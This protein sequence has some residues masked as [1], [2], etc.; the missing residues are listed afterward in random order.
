MDIVRNGIN[1]I[2]ITPENKLPKKV[3]GQLIETSQA[4]NLFIEDNIKIKKIYEIVIDINITRTRVINSPMN[5]I[6]VVDLNKK[7]K[8]VYYDMDSNRSILELNSPYNI[9]FNLESNKI[10]IENIN[11]HIADAYFELINSR[12]LYNHIFYMIDVQYL[13]NVRNKTKVIS[14]NEETRDRDIYDYSIIENKKISEEVKN[15]IINHKSI[16]DKK[17]NDKRI[18]YNILKEVLLPQDNKVQIIEKNLLD[19]DD[20]EDELFDMEDEYL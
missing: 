4:E 17:D 9:F 8:I 7:F 5:K 11:I 18:S 19:L 2:G 15:T 13:G 10:E 12:T 20:V 6:V 1:V 16:V 14:F 3:N